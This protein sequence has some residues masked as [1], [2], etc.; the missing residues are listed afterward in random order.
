MVDHTHVNRHLVTQEELILHDDI[1]RS[2]FKMKIPNQ[3]QRE[4][5]QTKS[6]ENEEE[7]KQKE[8]RKRAGLYKKRGVFIKKATKTQW[9]LRRQ[10]TAK[11]TTI[12]F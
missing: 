10:H 2:Q 5:K 4:N 9:D 1:I 3:R 8:G 11:G 6:Q 7:T 12:L